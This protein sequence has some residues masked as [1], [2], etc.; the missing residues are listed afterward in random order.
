MTEQGKYQIQVQGRIG[1]RWIRWFE[2]MTVTFEGE[3]HD[4]PTTTLIGA[5]PDQ[6][7]LRGILNRIWDLNLTLVS[8]TRVEVDSVEVSSKE[9]GK[10]NE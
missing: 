5:V 6:A 10:T 2:G 8:V 9:G 1:E 3:G 7:A 4:S